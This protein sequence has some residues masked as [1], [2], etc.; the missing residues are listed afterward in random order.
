MENTFI[1]AA[2]IGFTQLVKSAFDRDYRTVV[3]IIGATAI[4]ALAGYF[5]IDG[6]SVANGVI[7]GLTASGVVT[8][9]QALGGQRISKV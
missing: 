2:V 9:G 3:I 4:G 7:Y 6:L 5:H 8:L 1:V